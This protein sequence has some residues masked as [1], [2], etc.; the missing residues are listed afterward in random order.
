MTDDERRQHRDE[1]MR[2]TGKVE[3]LRHIRKIRSSA[4]VESYFLET[5]EQLLPQQIGYHDISEEEAHTE[6]LKEGI[7]PGGFGSHVILGAL[8]PNQGGDTFICYDA[9][10]FH[11][12]GEPEFLA[13]DTHSGERIAQSWGKMDGVDARVLTKLM[14]HEFGND[15]QVA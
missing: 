12:D 4:F 3:A 11:G 5:L 2:L 6:A 7:I 10:P 9:P 13:W 15:K 1:Y 14:E 8:A